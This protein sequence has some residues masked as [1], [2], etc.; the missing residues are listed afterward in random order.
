MVVGELQR[1]N[2]PSGR[3]FG[4]DHAHTRPIFA[5]ST[6]GGVVH[7]EDQV[8]MGRYEFRHA[9]GP[10]VGGTARG[11]D[12]QH[13]AVCFMGL[14]AQLGVVERGCREGHVERSVSQPAGLR[15]ADVDDGM[16]NVGQT[17]RPDLG[18]LNPLVLR[19]LSRHDFVGVLDVAFFRNQN[20][21]GIWRMNSGWGMFQPLVQCGG[22][23]ASF[24]FL[25]E[26]LHPTMR[27]ASRS[28]FR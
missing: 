19:E 8:G 14:V 24:G 20:C 2:A 22:G 17:G 10:T 3:L 12:E 27:R 11:V 21:L 5:R 15:R 28:A 23:G 18:H 16:V 4:E 1:Q 26:S 13:V 6:I 9:S 7:L 25:R